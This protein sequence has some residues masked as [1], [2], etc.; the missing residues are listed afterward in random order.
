MTEIA[1][2]ETLTVDPTGGRLVAWAASLSAA[3]QIGTALCSTTFV[4]QHF[5]GKPEEAAAAILFGDEIGLTPTQSLQSVYVVSGKPALYARAM[6][7]I[8]LGAGH[9]VETIKKTDAEV[10]VRGRRRGSTTWT[11]ETWTTA[12]AKKA[13]YL[14]NKK[15]ESDP[16]AMLYARAASDICRQI[17]P[18]ALAGIGY[19]VEEMELAETPT[20]T[21]TRDDQA[22]AKATSV[23]RRQVAAAPEPVEPPLDDED[24]DTDTGEIVEAEVVTDEPLISDDQMRKM[25]VL[26][27]SVGLTDRDKVLEYV[28]GVIGRNVDSS[29]GLTKTEASRVIDALTELQMLAGSEPTL[30]DGAA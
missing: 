11:T 15:Y 17:A 12:R 1:L 22:T 4:P 16:Q 13:G 25:R 2:R 28:R 24:V 19:S 5:R 18:D 27:T 7:A 9:E 10:T 14:S 23:R 21:I 29:K 30:E 20:V 3:H 6:V 26:L 8:V